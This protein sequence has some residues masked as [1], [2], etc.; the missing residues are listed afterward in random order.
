M[1]LPVSSTQCV[2]RGKNLPI[3]FFT[4]R[5]KGERLKLLTCHV[6]SRRLFCLKVFLS[7]FKKEIRALHQVAEN[8]RHLRLCSNHSSRNP[9]SSQ[10]WAPL[11]WG[12]SWKRRLSFH[13]T[14]Q[15]LQPVHPPF[16]VSV[17]NTPPLPASPLNS[18][19][20]LQR[21]D[22]TKLCSGHA[23]ILHQAGSD[24]RPLHWEPVAW[25]LTTLW[26]GPLNKV[27]LLFKRSRAR[28]YFLLRSCKYNSC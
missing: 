27:S 21:R 16:A 7:F 10:Q 8:I 17:L 2:S 28:G 22:W 13:A 19:S 5:Q 11:R 25:K 3:V 20:A 1:K 4:D 14:L 24:V 12:N 26:S 15:P 23:P 18:L 6:S 9:K